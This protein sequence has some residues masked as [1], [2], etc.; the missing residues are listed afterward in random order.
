VQRLVLR[1]SL[2]M[3]LLGVVLGSCASLV[4]ARILVRTVEGMRSDVSAFLFVIPVL[5]LAA[6]LASWLPALRA[7]RVDP[8]VALRQE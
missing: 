4:A 1:G 6:F 7:S 8:I 2:S 5:F 3:T